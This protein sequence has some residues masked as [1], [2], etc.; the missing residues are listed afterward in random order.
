M[1][2]TLATEKKFTEK[3]IANYYYQRRQCAPCNKT[4]TRRTKF[5]TKCIYIYIL[6]IYTYFLFI[7]VEIFSL[8][9]Q[10]SKNPQ[11]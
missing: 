5:T 8:K 3:Y 1:Q 2:I 4:A 6:N 7:K 10:S 11:E 9:E